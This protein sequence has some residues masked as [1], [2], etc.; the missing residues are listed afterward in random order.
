MNARKLITLILSTATLIAPS[1]AHADE[2]IGGANYGPPPEAPATPSDMPAQRLALHVAPALFVPVGNLADATQALGG[3]LVGIDY[4]LSSH[5]TFTLRGG[6]LAAVAD[7]DQTIAGLHIKSSLDFAP[8]LGGV[9]WYI[10]QPNEGVFFA[11]EGG[12]IFA[13][14]S[15]R[16][17][18]QAGN[19]P[20]NVALSGSSTNF[21]AGAYVGYETGR[22]D[23]RAGVLTLDVGHPSN[24]TGVMATASLSFAQF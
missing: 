4:R 19:I 6:Y 16:M 24:S 20:V 11:T 17:L 7:Q 1:V 23:F 2:A 5:A 9:K 14:G 10:A 21:G 15:T 8:V 22:W 13:T 12:A 18:G 3:G